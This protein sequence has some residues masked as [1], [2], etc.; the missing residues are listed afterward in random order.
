MYNHCV[1]FRVANCNHN[2]GIKIATLI[3][4]LVP[5]LVAIFDSEMIHGCESGLDHGGV[6]DDLSLAKMISSISNP[7]TF[8]IDSLYFIDQSKVEL[9]KMA[10]LKSSHSSTF[11]LKIS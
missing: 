5:T 7:L 10:F 6:T 4:T 9:L 11:V 1:D 8:L 3:A 2:P